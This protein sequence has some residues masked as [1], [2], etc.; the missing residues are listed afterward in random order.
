[1]AGLVNCPRLSAIKPCIKY[2]LHNTI[3]FY[4][5]SC[6]LR[7]AVIL[8]TDHEYRI[9]LCF[10][11][12]VQS[13]RHISGTS[14]TRDSRPPI[15]APIPGTGFKQGYGMAESCSAITFH[16]PERYAYKYAQSVSMLVPSTEARIV[17]QET[18]K[19]CG[20]GQTD[21]IWAR[22]PQVDGLL[23]QRQSDVG[24]FRQGGILAQWRH[25]QVQ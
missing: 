13:R 9:F 10:W 24:G 11:S 5:V 4:E 7:G 17:D 14:I 15:G 21:E 23:E 3:E 2:L 22:G 18:G 25:W 19:D 16:P 12:A 6:F 1:M 8:R 20:V